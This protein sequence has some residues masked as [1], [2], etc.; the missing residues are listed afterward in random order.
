MKNLAKP[1]PN[2]E[3][4]AR[5]KHGHRLLEQL[6]RGAVLDHIQERYRVWPE[7]TARAKYEQCLSKG[8][9]PCRQPPTGNLRPVEPSLA[10]LLGRLGVL[11]N[12]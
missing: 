3:S 6:A 12:A 2:T 11:G 10:S 9:A 5:S 7:N 4:C 1:C 8:F